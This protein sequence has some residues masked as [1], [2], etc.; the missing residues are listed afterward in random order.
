MP[1]CVAATIWKMAGSPPASAPLRSPLSNDANGSLSFHSGCCGASAFTRAS[2]KTSWK[3]RGCSAQSV[4]SLSN[5]AMRSLTGTKSDEPTFVTFVTNSTIDFLAAPSFQEG[6]ESPARATFVASANAQTSMTAMTFRV[7]V[8]LIVSSFRNLRTSGRTRRCDGCGR[9]G[10][11]GVSAL[12]LE[13]PCQQASQ[14]QV[15]GTTAI[16]FSYWC[17][18]LEE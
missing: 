17:T 8:I 7:R 11:W 10:Y 18:H 3:Y 14:P 5:V 9:Q 15:C 1:V 13:A 4:P 16:L 6:R 2:A 12:Q